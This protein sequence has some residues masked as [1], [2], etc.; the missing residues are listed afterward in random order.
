VLYTTG[1]L[2]RQAGACSERYETLRDHLGGETY[3]LDTPIGLD[4]V[5]EVLGRKDAIWALRCVLPGQEANRDRIARLFA[6]ECAERVLPL[7]ERERP[8][9]PRPREAIATARRFAAGHA[10]PEELGAASDAASDAAGAAARSAA[11]SAAGSAARSAA[12]D[13]ARS[14]ARSAAY[15]AVRA[16][17]WAAERAAEREA[18]RDIFLRLLRNTTAVQEESSSL[19]MEEV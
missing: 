5:C 15:D 8:D 17:A 6:C 11:W 10:T 12:S 19:H 13:A 18:Q 1:R 4:V 14:A 2:A 7:F 9:D 16:A 3:G